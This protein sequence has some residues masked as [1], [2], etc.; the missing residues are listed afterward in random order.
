MATMF[1]QA[2]GEYVDPYASAIAEARKRLE[3]PQAPAFSPE[4]QQ[5][6]V[7]QN[8]REYLLGMA[9]G[10]SGDEGF[11][12]VG[13]QVLRQAMAARSP[14]VTERGTADPLRGTFTYSPEYLRELD[15]NKLAALERASAGARGNYESARAAARER[16]ERDAEKFENQKELRVLMR[17]L[18]GAGGGGSFTP[19]GFTP[20]GQRTV[21]NSKTG[22][23]YVVSMGPN[24]QPVYTPVT[25]PTTPK[26]TFDKAVVDAQENLAAANRADALIKKV[27]G[28]PGAFGW[29]GAAVGA[30]PGVVQ[31]R[32]GQILGITPAQA[33]LRAQV[34]RDAA[35]ELNAIY[36][37]AQSAGELARAAAWAPNASDDFET[38]I[39]KLEAA[40][41]WAANSARS[42]GVGVVN[43]AQGRSGGVRDDGAVGGGDPL[44]LRGGQ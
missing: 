39:T 2:L 35:M 24:G 5:Q 11:V 9:A 33:R 7:A 20:E 30:A 32:A 3:T 27:K 13:G 42:R 43:A 21:T 10:L 18:G 38:I 26:A 41:D 6:R 19:A 25:G 16:A 44:G 23:E 1:P 14:R 28:D 17:S 8:Q 34:T 37:A 40:R 4:Q 22:L 29:A 31:G 36:G 15:E 12:N